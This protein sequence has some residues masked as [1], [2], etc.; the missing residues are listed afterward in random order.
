MARLSQLATQ[1]CQATAPLRPTWTWQRGG[2]SGNALEL[3]RCGAVGG[4]VPFSQA[5]TLRGQT[6]AARWAAGGRGCA[7]ASS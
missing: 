5:G 6:W 1:S 7:G 2:H 4:P 3:G